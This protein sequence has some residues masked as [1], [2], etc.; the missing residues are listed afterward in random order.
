MYS[1]LHCI[2]ISTSIFFYH[3][4]RTRNL[5]L[6][7]LSLVERQRLWRG[8]RSLLP[9]ALCSQTKQTKAIP[10]I[11]YMVLIS[12]AKFHH[13]LLQVASLHGSCMKSWRSMLPGM[14]VCWTEVHRDRNLLLYIINCF[15]PPRAIPSGSTPK[16]DDG[17]S[18]AGTN[19]LMFEL[20]WR[21]F[22]RYVSL[23]LSV[24]HD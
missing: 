17:T 12:P 20:L 10:E 6:A 13:G 8:W 4:R 9:N 2:L 21:D 14:Q 22:F 1:F 11:A 3:V 5:L 16:N 7:L 23:T 18:D 24:G 15:C 19:W